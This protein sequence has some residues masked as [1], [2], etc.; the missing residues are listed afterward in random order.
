MWNTSTKK[1]V[2][3]IFE[4]KRAYTPRV[5]LRHPNDVSSYAVAQLQLWCGVYIFTP[6]ACALTTPKWHPFMFQYVHLCMYYTN[7][8]SWLVHKY[9]H[10]HTHAKPQWTRAAANGPL[11]GYNIHLS[12]LWSGNV[13]HPHTHTHKPRR[14]SC[15]VSS[16]DVCRMRAHMYH[17]TNSVRVC[18]LI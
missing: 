5:R 2:L 4:Q 11:H 15:V 17:K 8:C 14:V 1:V 7:T 16:S 3:Y 18:V 9:A 6:L 10:T 12:R 13:T